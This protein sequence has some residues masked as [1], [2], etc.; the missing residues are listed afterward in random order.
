MLYFWGLLNKCCIFKGF[1]FSTLFLLGQ[2]YSSGT[3]VNTVLHY[4]HIMLSFCQRNSVLGGYL[5]GVGFLE[6]IFAVTK[7]FLGLSEIPNS[8]DP[9]V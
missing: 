6:G 1:I 4:Y 8:P 2:F 7:C 5:F 3:S 9:Y